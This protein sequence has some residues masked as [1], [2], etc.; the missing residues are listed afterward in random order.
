MPARE[1]ADRKRKLVTELNS[2]INLKKQYSSTESGRNEL[3]AGANQGGAEGSAAE[4]PDG[5]LWCITTM[6]VATDQLL[7]FSN[8]ALLMCSGHHKHAFE[9]QTCTAISH[10]SIGPPSLPC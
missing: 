5:G 2:Y 8:N 9:Q 7:V 4:G 6:S 1:L 10:C 3:L